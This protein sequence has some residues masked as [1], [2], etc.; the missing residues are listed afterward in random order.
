MRHS[1]RTLVGPTL[2]SDT[3]GPV[4]RDCAAPRRDIRRDGRRRATRLR[5]PAR[6]LSTLVARGVVRCRRC[7]RTARHARARRGWPPAARCSSTRAVIRE[8]V[9]GHIIC[10]MSGSIDITW[11]S[12]VYGFAV[13]PYHLLFSR[14]AR[15]PRCLRCPGGP[16]WWPAL[17]GPGAWGGRPAPS[18]LRGGRAGVKPYPPAGP[19]AAGKACCGKDAFFTLR[20]FIC[21]LV[22]YARKL[23]GPEVSDI[24]VPTP[25]HAP[26]TAQH[27]AQAP[28]PADDRW[29]MDFPT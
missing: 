5:S 10:G 12:P 2:L 15:S 4:H 29:T 8:L 6:R 27:A 7:E 22:R 9:C 26:F 17:L 20:R 21:C 18:A 28:A 16:G 19:P 13:R 25:F 3:P 11:V 23:V 24:A 1:V 14:W